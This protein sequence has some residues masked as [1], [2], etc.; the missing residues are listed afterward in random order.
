MANFNPSAKSANDFNGGAK[1]RPQI[2]GITANDMNNLVEGMLHAQQNGDGGAK[3]YRHDINM[4]SYG[5]VEGDTFD[6]IFTIINRDPTNYSAS[7]ERDS[8][9]GVWITRLSGENIAFIP[10][11]EMQAS[12]FYFDGNGYLVSKIERGYNYE[13]VYLSI[14][15]FEQWSITYG[16][17]ANMIEDIYDNV[18][19]L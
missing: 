19:E 4:S 10:Q 18:T 5:D 8:R 6:I 15:N 13:G 17:D 14:F 12:G 11:H 9:D 2:D 3:L 16:V 1:W 7:A